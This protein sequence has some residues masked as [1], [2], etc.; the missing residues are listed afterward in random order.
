MH[1]QEWMNVLIEHSMSDSFILVT[2]SYARYERVNQWSGL[3]KT[4]LNGNCPPLFKPVG[5]FV[6]YQK[7]KHPTNIQV[8]AN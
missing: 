1:K 2:K 7:L 8:D 6:L 5:L 3:F 4:P